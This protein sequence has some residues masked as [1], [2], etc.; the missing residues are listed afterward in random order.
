MAKTYEG[1]LEKLDEY[2]W[3]IP[4]DA[5]QGMTVPG[6]I[7]ADDSMMQAMREDAALQQVANVATLVGIER[8]SLAM[9]DFHYG[10]GFPI[11]G[12]AATD[13]ETGVIS[14]GGVGY[15]INCGVRMVRT[16]LM[17]R[18]I[19]DRIGDLIDGVY[20]T[21]PAGVGGKGKSPVQRRE[22]ENVLINGAGWAVKQGYGRRE[23]L[24][25]LEEEGAMEGADPDALSDHAIER[26]RPQLG[27][28]GSGNHFLERVR[29]P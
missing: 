12:V 10:Y 27:T 23:D 25:V 14:P 28:L 5:N 1:K 2:R 9:P 29:S 21:V 6:I 4:V 7:Y 8:V 13:A 3:R 17:Y 18:D 26:G 16:D 20:S 24:A 11:G 15:D 19:K 22:L